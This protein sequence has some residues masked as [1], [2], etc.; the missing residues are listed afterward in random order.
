[1]TT[2]VQPSNS[3]QVTKS[4][5]S[6]KVDALAPEQAFDA[7][8]AAQWMLTAQM[9]RAST[10]ATTTSSAGG[11]RATLGGPAN[12]GTGAPN[13]ARN[14]RDTSGAIPGGH[15]TNRHA[16]VADI[17][18]LSA[19]ELAGESPS[20]KEQ[21]HEA[22]QQRHDETEGSDATRGAP[23]RNRAEH[24][25]T[26]F[27]SVGRQDRPGASATMAS[28]RHHNVSAGTN[29][30]ATPKASDPRIAPVST[31]SGSGA[32]P[33]APAARTGPLPHLRAQAP[34][35]SVAT[36]PDKQTRTTLSVPLGNRLGTATHT[37]K[38]TLTTAARPAIPPEIQDP[39]ASQ[40]LRGLAA[41]LRQ[42]NGN[43]T[44][45]LAPENL[46]NLRLSIT[47]RKTEVVAR[48][49]ATSEEAVQTL[50]AH[51]AELR[52]ALEAQ[53]FAISRI[54]VDH[55]SPAIME[56]RERCD[57][58]PF[59]TPQYGGGERPHGEPAQMG[60]DVDS[61]RPPDDEHR[62]GTPIAVS[63]VKEDSYIS[64]N[65]VNAVA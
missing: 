11:A 29:Q 51:S 41:A 62:T 34:T 31:T 6:Q 56:M 49:E 8:L 61:K 53:G 35:P 48:V 38:T 15:A 63:S 21:F 23:R 9:S 1:M 47:V 36:P 27:E 44:L 39:V 3:A 12:R 54:E 60:A 19:Q 46:G 42:G 33:T 55:V 2:G 5:R 10:T 52:G 24:D 32:H 20:R 43:V 7:A 4:T 50:K 25:G 26:R 17:T 30:A 58:D 14:A 59:T 64:A 18:Q 65:G 28:L 16:S 45:R 57:S 13:Q 37:N 40:A 22:Q